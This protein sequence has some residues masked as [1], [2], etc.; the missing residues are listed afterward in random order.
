MRQFFYFFIVTLIIPFSCD[1]DIEVDG[2]AFNPEY[3][4]IRNPENY[5]YD[6]IVDCTLTTTRTRNGEEYYR[7]VNEW[8]CYDV[9]ELNEEELNELESQ[10]AENP[11]IRTEDKGSYIQT[12]RSDYEI[13][14]EKYCPE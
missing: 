1:P 6:F 13:T 11:F 7:E 9:K 5:R 14:I 10:F 3:K 4:C 8:R 2:P 12:E